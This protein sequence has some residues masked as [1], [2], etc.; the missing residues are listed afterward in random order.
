MKKNLFF[1][2]LVFCVCH[3]IIAQLSAQ[4]DVGTLASG[5]PELRLNDAELSANLAVALHGTTLQNAIIYSGSDI[6]G[7]Y[8]YIRADGIRAGQTAP[9]RV[10]M[11]LSQKDGSLVFDPEKG[12]VMECVPQ[13]PGTICDMNIRERCKQQNCTG[14][15]GGGC[16][17]RVVFPATPD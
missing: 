5:E 10:A 2:T 7:V 8:Y 11:I 12:C 15:N 17:V 14:T 16:N 1:K 3:L 9:S 6:H 4:I 13:Q